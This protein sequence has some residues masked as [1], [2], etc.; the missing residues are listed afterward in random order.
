MG[1]GSNEIRELMQKEPERYEIVPCDKNTEDGEVFENDEG[2]KVIV[3]KVNY[4]KSGFCLVDIKPENLPERK[5]NRADEIEF[6]ELVEK[7]ENYDKDYDEDYDEDCKQDDSL[8]NK[9]ENEYNDNDIKIDNQNGDSI[10][11]FFDILSRHFGDMSMRRVK[12]LSDNSFLTIISFKNLPFVFI[13]SNLQKCYQKL[14]RFVLKDSLD[15]IEIYDNNILRSQVRKI[16]E[17]G[18]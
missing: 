18:E 13:E 10:I 17:A 3:L 15:L 16:I 11:D 2:K 1:L 14:V 8:L 6:D 4:P 12:S 5:F 7:E 9:T